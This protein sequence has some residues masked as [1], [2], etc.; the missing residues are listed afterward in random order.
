LGIRKLAFDAA[1]EH[2]P[3]IE[4]NGL[5]RARAAVDR[6]GVL[7]ERGTRR[8][9][10]VWKIPVLRTEFEWIFP[11]REMAFLKLIGSGFHI[12]RHALDQ[13][14]IKDQSS[15]R[16]ETAAVVEHVVAD[17]LECQRFEIRVHLERV[18]PLQES[19]LHFLQQI[20]RPGISGR[21]RADVGGHCEASIAVW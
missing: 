9:T 10:V 15:T 16:C 1:P 20:A 18:P 14:V 4:K 19:D 3:E 17:C 5:E 2:G 7:R 6:A 12:R 13:V 11:Q 8:V 21:E